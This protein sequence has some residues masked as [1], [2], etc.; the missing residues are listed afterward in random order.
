MRRVLLQGTDFDILRFTRGTG[1]RIYSVKIHRCQH[2]CRETA[3]DHNTIEPYNAT[4]LFTTPPEEVN[5]VR[6]IYTRSGGDDDGDDDSDDDN[7]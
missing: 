2:Q 3:F 1:L 5:R 6:G 4:K 7:D